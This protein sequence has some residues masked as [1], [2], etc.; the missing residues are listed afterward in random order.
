MRACF[1]DGHVSHSHSD[2]I[3]AMNEIIQKIAVY[4]LPVLFAVTLHEVAHA[5]AAK[6]FGDLT[7]YSQGR[8][9]LNPI[10]HID[11][12]GTILI[13][14]LLALV[15][16][17]FLFGYAKPVPIDFSQL[18]QPKK[19]MAWVALAGPM[20]NFVMGLMW[21]VLFFVLD[22]ADIDEAYVYEVARAGVEFNLMLFAFNLF[23]LPPFDGGRILTSVLP[24]RYAFR[25]A[26]IEPYGL[27]I[28]IGLMLLKLLNYWMVPVITIAYGLLNILISPLKFLLT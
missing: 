4:A 24:N 28:V 1:I 9:S 10:K 17:P 11:P 26:R 27:F 15:G 5:Y 25:F 6:Y 3:A 16:S 22:A 20:A 12:F 14:L 2:K 23:P 13:P 19:D 21:M 7:A 8:M 18:R